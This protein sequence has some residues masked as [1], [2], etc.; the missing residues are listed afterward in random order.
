MVTRHQVV[1]ILEQRSLPRS[2]LRINTGKLFNTVFYAF[3][4]K[5]LNKQLGTLYLDAKS[6]ALE[7]DGA[8]E[9]TGSCVEVKQGRSCHGKQGDDGRVRERREQ[10][11][12]QEVHG[13]RSAGTQKNAVLKEDNI[14]YLKYY[15]IKII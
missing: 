13:A 8:P 1:V 11:L 12:E 15:N 2:I 14:K 10:H 3:T 6:L 9:G 5:T 7:V 4:K